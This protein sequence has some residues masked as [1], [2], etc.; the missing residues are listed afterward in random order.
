MTAT[1]HRRAAK[2]RHAGDRVPGLCLAVFAAIWIALAIA[3][4]YR[5]DWLLENALTALA[6]P[7]AILTYRRWRLSDRAYVQ[8]TLF[9]IL[10]TV[11]SHYTYSEVP[12]GD[13]A[14]TALGLTRNHYDRLVHFAFG[15]LMLRPVRELTLRRAQRLGPRASAWLSVAQIL[16]CSVIYEFIEWGVAAVVDPQAGTAYLGTQGDEWDSQK[17]M[18]CAAAGALIAAAVEWAAAAGAAPRRSAQ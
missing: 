11:G 1:G 7:L 2:L 3:P 5:E 15:L 18:A 14:R 8:I 6:V 13:W 4:R 12:L 17:D 10:H 9:L 16:A